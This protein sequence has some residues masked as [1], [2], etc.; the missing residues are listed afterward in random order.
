[1]V[2]MFYGLLEQSTIGFVIFTIYCK[3]PW[4]KPFNFI[5]ISP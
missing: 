5:I 4:R 2:L 3:M 1:M